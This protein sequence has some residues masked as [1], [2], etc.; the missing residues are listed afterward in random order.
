MAWEEIMHRSPNSHGESREEEAE[1][2][3]A[4]NS[5]LNQNFAS[6]FFFA[7]SLLLAL[8][9]IFSLKNGK[10]II[11][12][13][14]KVGTYFAWHWNWRYLLFFV[15]PA[16]C[17]LA[18]RRIWL[19]CIMALLELFAHIFFSV[20]NSYKYFT[21]KRTM[22]MPKTRDT[23]IAIEWNELQNENGKKRKEKEKIAS[24]TTTA[25]FLTYAFMRYTNTKIMSLSSTDEIAFKCFTLA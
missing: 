9:H 14:W 25:Y 3:G 4:N 16:V 17:I 19:A 22:M 8:S 12:Y 15:P 5:A 10:I 13:A 21:C 11:K 20:L 2:R 24:T 1:E 23:N 18:S 6:M 7:Y